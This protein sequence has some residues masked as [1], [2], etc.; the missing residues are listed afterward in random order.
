[1]N[2]E[3]M[4]P[5]TIARERA[6]KIIE[7][8][9]EESDFYATPYMGNCWQ[10]TMVSGGEWVVLHDNATRNLNV[11]KRFDDL[12]AAIRFIDTKAI[13]EFVNEYDFFLE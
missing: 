3:L 13:G 12:E 1:M 4:D 9:A 11:F 5:T 8:M 7:T 2:D 10:I 6:V